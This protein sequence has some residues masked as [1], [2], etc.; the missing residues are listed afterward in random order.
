MFRPQ[1]P[2]SAS[3]T[4]ARGDTF[5]LE[6]VSETTVL[7]DQPQAR[8]T[9]PQKHAAEA[10]H[11]WRDA[12]L[13]ILLHVLLLLV[14]VALLVVFSRH[15][16]HA[17]TLSITHASTTWAPLV[18][19]TIQQAFATIY[20]AAL[21][22]VTQ[23]L[24][25]RA[26]LRTRQT[27]TAVHDKNAAWLGLGSALGALWQQTKV[28]AAPGGVALV[29][30][31][32]A[33][34]FM[35][36]ISVPGLF[37]VVP[38]NASALQTVRTRLA[39]ANYT[40]NMVS[41][42]DGLL[43]YNQI[44]KIG[45][46]DSM[47]YDVVPQVPGASGNATVNAAV[48]DVQCMA[49][50]NVVIYGMPSAGTTPESFFNLDATGAVAVLK[51]PYYQAVYSGYVY[52][53]TNP[54]NNSKPCDQTN[55]WAPLILAS[56]VPIIDSSGAPPPTSS[57]N[58]WTNW[59][60]AALQSVPDPDDNTL[61]YTAMMTAVQ[62]V[63]CSVDIHDIQINVS[64]ATLQPLESPPVPTEAT[65]TSF[66]WPGDLTRTDS[67]LL[68]AQNAPSLS[69]ASGHQNTIRTTYAPISNLNAS[70]I[71]G[72]VFVARP[73]GSFFPTPADQL[74]LQILESNASAQV[75]LLPTAFDSFVTADLGIAAQN[76]TSVSLAEL[77]HSVAKALAAVHWYGQS[78]GYS[79]S[80]VLDDGQLQ[81]PVSVANPLIISASQSPITEYGETVV[82]VVEARYYL[83]L[84]LTPLI[85]GTAGS[86]VLLLVAIA[87]ILSPP[88]SRPSLSR[89]PAIDRAGIDSAGIL[90]ITWLLGNEPHIAAVGSPRLGALRTAGMFELNAGG[91]GPEKVG[92]KGRDVYSEVAYLD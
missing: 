37:H 63:A 67:R 91:G 31:Y 59:Q 62:M 83:N 73:E 30:F 17:A 84:S 9:V 3:T 26:A 64:A 58:P 18:V 2:A 86:A 29:A 23:R 69:P 53:I 55:C 49:L 22:L 71:A 52:N 77:N 46:L 54:A 39:R 36:H 81:S 8:G 45:L 89:G 11:H 80:Q 13:C 12:A 28:R 40:A 78:L 50:P 34:V 44:N 79:S 42:Y 32:L 27:L 15:Y 56:T 74:E 35:L 72:P 16:E 21:V 43:S 90:Q 57:G 92:G 41:A 61:W 51:L 4:R 68:A 47:V 19:G 24:A 20:T 66:A 70:Q 88:S 7:T 5:V 60:A 1:R 48:Y 76:R 33:C 85:V 65:W 38:Y 87:L 10:R 25:L 14:H 82:T 6:E 75:L